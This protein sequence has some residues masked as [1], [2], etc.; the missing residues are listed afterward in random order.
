MLII[1]KVGVEKRLRNG[2]SRVTFWHSSEDLLDTTIA[3]RP[4]F[5]SRGKFYRLMKKCRRR[6]W[7]AWLTVP[8]RGML[9][10]CR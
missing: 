6:I 3:N 7:L 2:F 1:T 5:D 9:M 4:H 8:E 10:I